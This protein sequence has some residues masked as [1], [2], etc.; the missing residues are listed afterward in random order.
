MYIDHVKTLKDDNMTPR[1]EWRRGRVKE[2]LTGSYK[3]VRGAE[4]TVYLRNDGT[5]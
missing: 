1:S 2:L 4:L 3:R 5:S